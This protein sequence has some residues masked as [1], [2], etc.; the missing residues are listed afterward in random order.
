M[1]GC[2]LDVF[3]VTYEQEAMWIHDRMDPDPS[4]Y[5][6]SWVCRLRGSVDPSAVEWAVTQ[7]LG[8]HQALRS[9][10]DLH[11]DRIVQIVHDDAAVVERLSCPHRELNDVLEK[12]VRRPLDIRISPLRVTLLELSPDDVLLVI[13]FHHVVV[14]DWALA[15][16]E[17]EFQEFYLA[18]TLGRPARLAPLPLQ[19]REYAAAQRAA[20]IDPSVA[21]Y[22]QRRLRDAPAQSTIPA[23]RP[24]PDHPSR[25]GGLVRFRLDAELGK[26]L[27]AAAR[28]FRVTP[29]TLLAATLTALLHAYNGSPDQV[30]GIVV[31][32]RGPA[33]LN[34]MIM[35]LA[36]L[37]PM[38][39]RV[40]PEEGFAE[41]VASTKDAV[42]GALAHRDLPFWLLLKELEWP[43]NFSR[44]P[45]CQVVLVVDDVPRPRLQLPDVRAERLY[46]HSGK[47]KFD[48]VITLV[49]EGDSYEGF[50]VYASDLFCQDTAQQIVVDF[51]ALATAVIA[52]PT[53]ALAD[54]IK[55]AVASH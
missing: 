42:T 47:S 53:R 34:Q 26:R 10:I 45:L 25:R 49:K 4:I 43:T 11:A 8:R 31:S 48:I 28:G 1:T 55:G 6:E 13:Q 16:L 33:E 7:I 50:L 19:P 46:V 14:D 18:R 38:R 41:L 17:Q 9:S 36:D 22:W 29:F 12:L 23:D 40:R 30:L 21:A 32:R 51:C 24:P 27:R 39:Q 3:P 44:P 20:G 52:E 5:L 15:V 35:C 37:M 2:S 54:V